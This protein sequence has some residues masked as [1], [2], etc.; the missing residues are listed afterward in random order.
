M[1]AGTLERW[2]WFFLAHFSCS[3]VVLVLIKAIIALR[4]I[5]TV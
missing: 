4:D 1:Y 5:T 2:K 3:R